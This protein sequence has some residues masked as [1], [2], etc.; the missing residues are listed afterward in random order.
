MNVVV[1]RIVQMPSRKDLQARLDSIGVTD[2][3][4]KTNIISQ[5]ADQEKVPLGVAM[6]VELAYVDYAEQY[7]KF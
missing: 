1:V 5:L 7:Y 4:E 2:S 6:A 3:I